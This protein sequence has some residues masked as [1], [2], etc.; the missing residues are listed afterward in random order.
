[1]ADD[2]NPQQGPENQ[3][4]P[5]KRSFLREK[6]TDEEWKE[7]AAEEKRKLEENLA[8]TSPEL[9]PASFLGFLQEL[10]FRAMIALGQVPSPIDNQLGVDLQAARYTID[11]LAVLEEKTRGNLEPEEAAFLTDLIHNLRLAFVQVSKNPPRPGGTP[12]GE[13]ENGPRIIT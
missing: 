7:K 6:T 10:S 1:M 9:P 3:Q 4:G 2:D 13:A 12:E 11:L 5:E 8:S